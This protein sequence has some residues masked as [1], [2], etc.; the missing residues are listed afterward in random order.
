MSSSS[1][2]PKS[3][4]QI[5]T[6]ISLVHYTHFQHM[7]YPLLLWEPDSGVCVKQFLSNPT[8]L[9]ETRMFYRF[10]MISWRKKPNSKYKKLNLDRCFPSWQWRNTI[11]SSW[12]WQSAFSSIF[13]SAPFRG[14]LSCSPSFFS[15]CYWQQAFFSATRLLGVNSCRHSQI[16]KGLSGF[17]LILPKNNIKHPKKKSKLRLQW[18]KYSKKCKLK[19]TY[20]INMYIY[21]YTLYIVWVG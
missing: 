16:H 18:S 14:Q 12:R 9:V 2:F 3:R 11:P 10:P 17:P 13:C 6:R 19:K 4:T 5:C 1:K 7:M 21:M 8:V 15:C 20:I